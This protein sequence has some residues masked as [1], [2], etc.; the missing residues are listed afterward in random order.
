M[1]SPFN[2]AYNKT[3]LDILLKTNV[4]NKNKWDCEKCFYFFPQFNTLECS[5]LQLDFSVPV[6]MSLDSVVDR[7]HVPTLLT[8]KSCPDWKACLH[9]WIHP[10]RQNIPS[11]WSCTPRCPHPICASYRTRSQSA[12]LQTAKR[13]KQLWTSRFHNKSTYIKTKTY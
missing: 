13:R 9:A 12:S 4:E 10:P 2:L 3:K 7:L 1:F 11:P 6:F 8:W 5:T